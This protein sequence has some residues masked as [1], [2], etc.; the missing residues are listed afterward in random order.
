M[1]VVVVVVVVVVLGGGG[2]GGTSEDLLAQKVG[3]FLQ[4]LLGGAE[5]ADAA[6]VSFVHR[7]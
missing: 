1:V 5:S 4:E 6:L 2:G 3:V 7:Y